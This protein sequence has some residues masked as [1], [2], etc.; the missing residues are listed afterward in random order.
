MNSPHLAVV[1]AEEMVRRV[2]GEFLE[3]PGLRLTRAQA[4]RMWGLDQETC[5]EVLQT[6]VDTKFL[7]LRSDGTYARLSDGS[8]AAPLRMTK[9][10]RAHAS[11][12]RG[13]ASRA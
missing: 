8:A 2:R 7:H 13:R 9:A 3:M 12:H 1:S 11:E 10:E 6:L 4:Q 5:A